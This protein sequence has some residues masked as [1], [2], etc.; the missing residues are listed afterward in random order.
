MIVAVGV[1]RVVQVAI[2]QVIDVTPVWHGLVA[3]VRAMN[4]RLIVPRAAV[5]WRTFLGIHSVYFNP[6]VVHMIAMRVVQVAIVKIVRVTIV[7]HSRMAAIR[8]MLVAV[9][10]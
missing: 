2:H 10:T 3:T 9:R 8:P 4:V 7:L 5:S 6:V 1:V